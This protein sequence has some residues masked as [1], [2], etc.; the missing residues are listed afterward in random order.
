[1]RNRL[2][3]FHDSAKNANPRPSSLSGEPLTMRGIASRAPGAIA[4]LTLCAGLMSS[5]AVHASPTC[6]DE[7]ATP[8]VAPADPAFCKGLE[9]IVKHPS[10]FPLNTYETALNKY[11]TALCH[12][13]EHGGWKSDTRI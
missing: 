13:D 1:M 10:S 2:S 9:P 8:Q 4:A 11:L 3:A 6:P 7:Q 5:L 12:R